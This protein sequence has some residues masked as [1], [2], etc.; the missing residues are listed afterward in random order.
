ME[1]DTDARSD[2]GILV[3]DDDAS[4]RGILAQYLG[5]EGFR[6]AAE[7][8][9]E[10]GLAC[11]VRG[12]WDIVITD[13]RMPGIGGLEVLRR[14]KESRPEAEVI[15]LTG[16]ATI[17]DGVEAMREGAYDFL[18]KPVQVDQI[19]AVVARCAEWIRHKRSHAELEAV[20]RRL[21]EVSRMKERFLAVTDHELRTPVTVIDGMLHHVMRQFADD[22]PPK[23]KDRLDSVC[24]VSRRLVHLVRDIHDL[25]QS[26]TQTFPL[27]REE[28]GPEEFA[29]GVRVD[30]AMTAFS[31]DLEL[32]LAQDVPEGL[33][34]SVDG[35]RVRQAVSELIQNAV[36]ATPDGGAVAVRLFTD[37]GESGARF[38]VSVADTGVG[39]DP[40]EQKKIF[41]LF[42]GLGDER[43][44]HSSKFE[45]MG[46]GLGIGLSIAL[47][48][49]RAHGGG[50]ELQS[51]P[52]GGSL[53]T[54]W[55]PLS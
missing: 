24:Q 35:H 39:I 26:R 46:S 49:A 31:R 1:R 9:G 54:L 47:E 45:F 36:K 25:L 2:I 14:V 21:L 13:L 48:I 15:V 42:Y 12:Q 19:D 5:D 27:H 3:I 38:C 44:H 23:A 43:H 34:C 28:T 11:L 6:V 33:R 22:I 50:I 4:I 32:T 40:Q 30:F 20:N 18:L 52:Q 29:E 16:Y 8:C 55:V 10:A 37:E 53:F 17:R 7:G 51:H 41:E